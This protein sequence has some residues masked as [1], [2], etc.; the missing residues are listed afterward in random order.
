M[1]ID[2]DKQRVFESMEIS[3]RISLTGRPEEERI[4]ICNEPLFLSNCWAADGKPPSVNIRIF[5]ML[6]IP[7][8]WTDWFDGVTI[9]ALDAEREKRI[10]EATYILPE[11]I[12]REA[13]PLTKNE[14]KLAAKFGIII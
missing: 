7:G 10:K 14:E 2:T 12:T 11:L 9:Q 1:T 13:R 4:I 5:I 8:E 3:R 6:Y